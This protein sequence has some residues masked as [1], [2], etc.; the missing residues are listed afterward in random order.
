MAKSRRILNFHFLVIF[1]GLSLLLSSCRSRLNYPVSGDEGRSFS[2]IVEVSAGSNSYHVYNHET[3][4]L[5]KQEE[6]FEFL[7]PPM[8]IG[9]MLGESQERLKVLI[10]SESIRRGEKVKVIPLGTILLRED[11]DLQKYVV[12]IPAKK[13]DQTIKASSFI[14]LSLQY[15]GLKGTIEY[16]LNHYKGIGKTEVLEWKDEDYAINELDKL[17]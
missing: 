15:P 1:F 9:S 4:R 6:D 5:E 2:S 12:S 7:P 16:W 17:N 3:N 10:L 8:N 14:D 11:D 13:E